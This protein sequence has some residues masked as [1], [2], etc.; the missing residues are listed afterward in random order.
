MFNQR[1]NAVA[2]PLSPAN[3]FPPVASLRGAPTGS[4]VYGI[5]A[6]PP[7]S[8]YAFGAMRAGRFNTAANG[9]GAGNTFL[10]HQQ[11]L[12]QQ[13]EEQRALSERFRIYEKGLAK[14]RLMWAE[15][16]HI[17][18]ETSALA[19]AGAT[20]SKSLVDLRDEA[21][22]YNVAAPTF[23]A[24][25]FSVVDNTHRPLDAPTTA[26]V[27]GI[28]NILPSYPLSSADSYD[29]VR[30]VM[31]RWTYRVGGVGLRNPLAHLHYV[32]SRTPKTGESEEGAVTEAATSNSHVV[33][34]GAQ[35]TA[36]NSESFHHH[37]HHPEGYLS[38]PKQF[39]K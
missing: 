18:P 26:L 9:T 31:Q 37:H 2:S 20:G 11:Q 7:T 10:S 15:V 22:Y 17:C 6:N 29:V 33:S 8:A 34:H 28:P 38:A 23:G 12:Q 32:H 3:S 24:A 21:E 30:E 19:A 5:A 35:G 1:P 27:E 13:Q 16:L 25:P 39:R 36:P 4:S 14:I